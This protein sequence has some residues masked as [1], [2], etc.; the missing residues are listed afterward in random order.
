MSSDWTTGSRALL[1]LTT[2]A[3]GVLLVLVGLFMSVQDYAHEVESTTAL[4]TFGGT[5]DFDPSHRLA[6]APWL[7]AASVFVS[8]VAVWRAV[9]VRQSP[10]L[11]RHGRRFV[12]L[13]FAG[14][15]VLDLAYVMDATFGLTAPHAVRALLI[16]PMY[17]LAGVLVA[18]AAYRLSTLIRPLPRADPEA[19]S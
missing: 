18:G 11:R 10:R 2:A 17:A 9:R 1:D 7:L 12:G 16:D 19:F 13:L 8:V 5:P 4:R 15:G 6:Y 3:V 14:S